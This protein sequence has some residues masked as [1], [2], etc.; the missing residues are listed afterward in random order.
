MGMDLGL[1]GKGAVVAAAS[2]GLGEAI[3]RTLASEG[4]RLEI[5]SRSG[6][7]IA[8]A[9]S[10]IASATGSQVH[11]ESVDVS[12]QDATIAWIDACAD[13][14]G[15]IDIAIANAGG[16]AAA[17]FDDTV[18]EDWDAAYALTLRSAMQFALAVRPHLHPGSALLFMTSTSVREP[19]SVL[20]MSTIFRAG[21]ASLAK[22]LANDWGP[23]GIRVNHLIPG[24]IATDRVAGLDAITAERMGVGLDE[25]VKR[26]EAMIPLGRYGRPS[27]YA[28]AAAFLVSP[29]AA[30]ITGATLQVDGGSMHSVI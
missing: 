1:A 16:P 28:A 6:D 27:E 2:Q 14:L 21:V 15:G 22:L 26:S 11:G 29:A 9:A 25:I 13:R 17:R 8:A 4:C 12:D 18:G 24:R 19:S 30:Y 23:D 5:S 10:S 7:R 3:A 20:A